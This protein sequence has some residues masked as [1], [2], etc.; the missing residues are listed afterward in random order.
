MLKC[1]SRRVVF[2]KTGSADRV[3]LLRNEVSYPP[4]VAEISANNLIARKLERLQKLDNLSLADFVAKYDKVR[5][6]ADDD[7]DDPKSLESVTGN[8]F[9]VTP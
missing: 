6:N 9:Q 4:G 3:Y 5:G 7:E 2:I 1:S 8:E